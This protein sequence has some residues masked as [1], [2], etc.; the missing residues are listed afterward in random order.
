VSGGFDPPSAPGS[1][2]PPPLNAPPPP[3]G[4]HQVAPVPQPYPYPA[5]PPPD[6]KATAS[7]VLGIAGLVLL[8]TSTGLLAPLSI[9][10]SILGWVFARGREGNAKV[11]RICGIIGVALGVL[12]ILL[13][14][15]VI[16]VAVS[17]N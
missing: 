8:V 5:S 7:M 3:P 1:N 9:P 4:Y 16:A 12:A 17:K 13:W 2:P 15:A 14:G 6:S 11:G 10:C